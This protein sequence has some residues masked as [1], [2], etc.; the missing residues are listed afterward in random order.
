MPF[1]DLACHQPRALS[2]GLTAEPENLK[3]RS[4]IS[5]SPNL[6]F[7][8]SFNQLSVNFNKLKGFVYWQHSQFPGLLIIHFIC[9][10]NDGEDNAWQLWTEKLMILSIKLS[11]P[12]QCGLR[13]PL[14][15]KLKTEWIG[16]DGSSKRKQLSLFSTDTHH[17][18]WISQNLKNHQ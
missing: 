14:S 3:G 5:C 11:L 6:H 1:D 4:A 8:P 18:H 2:W 9:H 12:C 16:N 15:K 7:D 13:K 10:P 17:L